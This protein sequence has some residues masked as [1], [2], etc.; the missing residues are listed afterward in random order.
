M[1][2]KVLE[3]AYGGHRRDKMPKGK[4]SIGWPVRN[5]SACEKNKLASEIK[6][7]RVKNS[8]INDHNLSQV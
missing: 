4:R 7:W 1:V 2:I 3:A 6:I 5:Y 8:G